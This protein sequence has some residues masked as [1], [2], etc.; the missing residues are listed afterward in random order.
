ML[1]L[2]LTS[3][4]ELSSA[5]D[6]KGK[7]TK[8]KAENIPIPDNATPQDVAWLG[9]K[10][11]LWVYNPTTEDRPE[12]PMVHDKEASKEAGKEVWVENPDT[13]K[14]TAEQY[15]ERQRDQLIR[16]LKVYPKVLPIP[17]GSA[18]IKLDTIPTK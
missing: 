2:H 3:G 17:E 13:K 5:Y 7:R 11:G 14:E 18:M 4:R 16:M 9:H 8:L 10:N 15:R 12:L 1:K 6:A